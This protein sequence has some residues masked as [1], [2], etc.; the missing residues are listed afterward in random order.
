MAAIV[1][2]SGG[3]NG[4]IW[5]DITDQLTWKTGKSL[6]SQ[7]VTGSGH[8]VT[9][10]TVSPY[11]TG[12]YDTITVAQGE[13]YRITGWIKKYALALGTNNVVDTKAY[14]YALLDANQSVIA[15]PRET[16]P[17]VGFRQY[18][19]YFYP[20]A[21]LV[22]SEIIIP[23]SASYLFL[24]NLSSYFNE[25]ATQYRASYPSQLPSISY[26]LDDFRL[27]KLVQ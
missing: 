26:S 2:G 12:H 13:R 17:E 3:N 21:V 10:V 22:T 27:E 7:Q 4:E 14:S 5:Q 16:E 11:S 8:A 25:L 6:Y 19:L 1:V 9:L 18:D 24:A 23:A 15:L 20:P